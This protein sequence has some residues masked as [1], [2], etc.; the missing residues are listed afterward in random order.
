MHR[1][2]NEC[3]TSEKDASP[4]HFSILGTQQ[5]SPGLEGRLLL[6][7]MVKTLIRDPWRQFF[8]A[9]K[10]SLSRNLQPWQTWSVRSVHLAYFYLAHVIMCVLFSLVFP[11]TPE[12]IPILE[13][14]A[15]VLLLQ[16]SH[17]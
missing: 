8:R 9:L 4:C 10:S 16:Y 13:A 5:W 3:F 1:P 15:I 12:S 11:P 6:L 2:S 14:E 7:H 17:A